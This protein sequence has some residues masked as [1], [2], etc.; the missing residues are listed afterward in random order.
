MIFTKLPKRLLEFFLAFFLFYNRIQ[1]SQAREKPRESNVT[2]ER[3][4]NFRQKKEEPILK[5]KKHRPRRASKA[6]KNKK[7]EKE[8][9]DAKTFN[10][11]KEAWK[12]FDDDI[13]EK[14]WR[15]K[16]E[17]EQKLMK[18]DL[19]KLVEAPKIS[20][21]EPSAPFLP[22]IEKIIQKD[23]E[24]RI[25]KNQQKQKM[26]QE[27]IQAT[28]EKN[29][30]E[31]VNTPLKPKEFLEK[32]KLFPKPTEISEKLPDLPEL[33]SFLQA[34]NLEKPF[35]SDYELPITAALLL[36]SGL[37]IGNVT[38]ITINHFVLKRGTVKKFIEL[39]LQ[40]PKFQVNLAVALISPIVLLS[41]SNLLHFLLIKRFNKNYFI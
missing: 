11:E 33:S 2:Q 6:S 8:K 23:Y 20:D 18:N 1:F 38:L 32:P 35:F 16:K 29:L 22:E 39:I 19:P 3:E 5:E 4:A 7:L 26:K 25:K 28:F 30:K 10:E 17:Q 9:I 31:K 14:G 34:A 13:E 36:C 27:A 15:W 37:S 21:V 41:R 24:D 40:D 12:K